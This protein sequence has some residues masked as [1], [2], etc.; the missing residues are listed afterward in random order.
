MTTACKESR[1][2]LFA[3]SLITEE[4]LLPIVLSH[5]IADGRRTTA[6]NRQHDL[7][8]TPAKPDPARPL[9]F[10]KGSTRMKSMW[11]FT[12]SSSEAITLELPLSFRVMVKMSPL[13]WECRR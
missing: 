5:H 6:F 2:D 13:R 9:Y 8:N 3:I 11:P 10:T 12:S 4:L 1:P 7:G